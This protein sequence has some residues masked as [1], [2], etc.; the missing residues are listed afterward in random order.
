MWNDLQNPRAKKITFSH[1]SY[2]SNGRWAA[3]EVRLRCFSSWAKEKFAASFFS[4]FAYWFSAATAWN[5]KYRI[6]YQI[7]WDL[8]IW[9]RYV[10]LHEIDNIHFFCLN[11][12]NFSY[13]EGIC[14]LWHCLQV[15]REQKQHH[16]LLYNIKADF[17]P[18]LAQLE[19][20]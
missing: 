7:L 5:K 11:L 16:L 12:Q 3:L 13:T 2:C 20:C 8:N 14:K 17:I 6:S 18:L 15:W 19:L 4:H 1:C 9:A 10:Q